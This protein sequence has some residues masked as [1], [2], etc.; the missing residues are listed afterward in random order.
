MSP[1]LQY[2]QDFGQDAVQIEGVV[3]RVRKNVVCGPVGKLQIVKITTDDEGVIRAG[4]QVDSDSEA[5]QIDKCFALGT[6]TSGETQDRVSPAK[7]VQ[8]R[9]SLAQFRSI[10]R[11]IVAQVKPCQFRY[12]VS[13][14]ILVGRIDSVSKRSGTAFP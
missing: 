3:E 7:Q 13:D 10:P 5:A 9:E 8:L 6:Y 4:I 1:W 2:A 11:V 14:V 12:L